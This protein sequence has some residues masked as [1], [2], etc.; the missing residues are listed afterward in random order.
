MTTPAWAPVLED[1]AAYVTSR[2]VDA[3][4]PGSDT[5]IGTFTADT[6]PTD[7]QVLRLVGTA[8]AWVVNVTGDVV[9]DLEETATDVAA[10]RAAAL[11]E[12]SYPDRDG[13]I[14]EVATVLLEQARA[15]RDEL[16]AA[17]RAGGGAG[18]NGTATPL[19]AFPVAAPWC[20][21]QPAWYGRW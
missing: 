8:T 20:N 21:D 17:N 19:G 9:P 3:V 10:M 2:T 13:D 14:D 16:A 11:I 7:T 6:Y 12:L 18:P 4:T 1:V 5:P 15:G